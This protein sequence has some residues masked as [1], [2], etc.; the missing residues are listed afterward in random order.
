M[1]IRF[2]GSNPIF[3]FSGDGIPI[4]IGKKSEDPRLPSGRDVLD[5]FSPQTRI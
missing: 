2:F 3:F 5:I 4:A 1:E